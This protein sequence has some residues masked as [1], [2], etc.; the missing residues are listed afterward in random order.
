MHIYI[1]VYIRISECTVHLSF[2]AFLDNCRIVDI[3]DHIKGA[4][5][6]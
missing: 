6:Y 5:I 2:A 4:S 1:Y 3:S